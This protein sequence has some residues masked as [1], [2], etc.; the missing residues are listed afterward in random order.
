MTFSQ[1]DVQMMPQ[2]LSI[3][4]R[5]LSGL[6]HGSLSNRI[7][8]DREPASSIFFARYASSYSFNYGLSIY[9]PHVLPLPNSRSK[10]T[11]IPNAHF[12]TRCGLSRTSRAPPPHP[13]FLA[14]SHVLLWRDG[15]D[16]VRLGTDSS[17]VQ[18]SLTGEAT[19]P[20]LVEDTWGT[21]R[22]VIEAE[23][24]ETHSL[25]RTLIQVIGGNPTG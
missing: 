7:L 8:L 15:E 11:C 16:H 23:N 20:L 17:L 19:A 6:H 25:A 2:A 1:Q 13:F 5:R 3:Q 24:I 14:S 21:G 10:S 9:L 4:Q 22:H 12:H 18:I